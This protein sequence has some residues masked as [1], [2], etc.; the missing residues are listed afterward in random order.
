[1]TLLV[2]LSSYAN[3]TMGD[4]NVFAGYRQD[5]VTFK[6]KVPSKRPTFK[7]KT[8]IKNVDIFQLGINARTTLG[9]NF[10][11][12]A[13][14]TWGWVI[15]GEIERSASM[16]DV[17]S[18][19]DSFDRVCNRKLRN[20]VDEKYVY[21]INAAIGYPFY[22]CDSTTV[23]APVIGYAYDAQN[24]NSFN[25]FNT[26]G[27]TDSCSSSE[28]CCKKGF[29]QTWYGPFVGL[30][31]NFRPYD[32]CYNL[33][34]S[35]EYHFG[36]SEIKKTVDTANNHNDRFCERF[37]M[38]GYVINLGAD[39]EVT[40]EWTMGLYFKYTDLCSSKH[41]SWFDG[42]SS[43]SSSSASGT[44]GKRTQEWT[45]YAINIELG[46]QF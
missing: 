6:N 25:N 44:R 3:A 2:G 29:V 4:V 35:A 26:H 21:D 14:A 33:Y 36:K 40:E 9:C 41:H 39:Y 23:V 24:F 17:F 38:D 16:R 15:N 34:A 46:R 27:L 1:M 8:E 31:F 7:E 5:Q 43:S 11:G 20:T 18:Y 12:R 37:D 42:S 10:Y 13:E 28:A 22:F 19:N 32:S 45:S 30:D